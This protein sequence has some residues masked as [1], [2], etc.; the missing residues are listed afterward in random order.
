MWESLR[1]GMMVRPFASITLVS[2]LRS[3]K[4]SCSV[5]VA[6]IFPSVIARASTKE[7]VEFVAIFALCRIVSVAIRFSSQD[8]GVRGQEDS[9]PLTLLLVRASERGGNY[10]F[11]E[12]RRGS[13]VH[14]RVRV[15]DSDPVGSIVGF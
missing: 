3:R 14:H 12:F 11:R 13:A 6:M 1:P 10:V 8:C 4:I 15:L 7:G 5:P 9:C 2:G